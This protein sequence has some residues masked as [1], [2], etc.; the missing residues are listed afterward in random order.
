MSEVVVTVGSQ[1]VV[2]GGDVGPT[3]KVAPNN[4]KV[5]TAPRTGEDIEIDQQAN[6]AAVDV[7][8]P[9]PAG[10]AGPAGPPGDIAGTTDQLPEGVVNLYYTD[11]RAEAV[12]NSASTAAVSLHI[13]AP[14]PHPQ[15]IDDDDIIDG[16]NF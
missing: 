7:G 2:V 9:G 15:Y 8:I 4:T 5:E 12:A 14:D 10:P 6:V 1:K 13:A 3:V 16:G 11:P